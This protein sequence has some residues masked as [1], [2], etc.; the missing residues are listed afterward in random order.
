[1]LL[2]LLSRVREQHTSIGPTM[3][4]TLRTLVAVVGAAVGVVG[5]VRVGDSC[6]AVIQRTDCCIFA[7]ESQ[8][9]SSG[10]A[11]RP[12]SGTAPLGRRRLN[13]PPKALAG[14]EGNPNLSLMFLQSWSGARVALL[15]VG[16]I[17]GLPFLLFVLAQLWIFLP[18]GPTSS[19]A[20]FHFNLI[21]VPLLLL[22][23]PLLLVVSWAIARRGTHE[24]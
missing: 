7:S 11:A 14:F 21:V 9:S 10:W 24:T 18:R 5:G 16:W 22:G 2:P 6:G 19:F 3:L 13:D 4:G 15:A 20:E 1:M 8:V 12:S 23:P 17:V